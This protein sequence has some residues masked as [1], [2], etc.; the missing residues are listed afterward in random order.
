MSS[1]KKKILLIG[2]PLSDNGKKVLANILRDAKIPLSDVAFMDLR[3]K[4]AMDK[5]ESMDPK[6]I[7]PMGAPALEQTLG[8]EKITKWRGSI[9]DY[10]GYKAIPTFDPKSIMTNWSWRPICLM[11]FLRIARHANED[12]KPME[13]TLISTPDFDTIIKELDRLTQGDELV[14]F[15]IENPDGYI[16]CIS[17]SDRPDW[18]MCVPFDRFSSVEQEVIWDKVKELCLST[19]PMVAH[20]AQYDMFYLWNDKG[21][22]VKNLYMDTMIAGNLLYAEFPKGLDFMVSIFTEEPY[23]KYMRKTK[24]NEVLY[25]Y[26]CLDAATTIEIAYKIK[27]K[28]EKANMWMFYHSYLNRLIKPI[29]RMTIRG[30]RIDTKTRDEAIKQYAEEI[31]KLQKEINEL[32]GHD[33]NV[34]S[35]KQMKDYLYTELGLPKQYRRRKNKNGYQ[36]SLSADEEAIEKLATDHP[37]PLFHRILKLRGLKKIKGTYLEAKVD[38]DGRMRASYIIG[39]TETGR[40]ASRKSPRGTGT[41]LQNVPKGIA[42]RIFTPD[43]EKVFVSAD[44]SQAEAYIVAYLAGEEALIRLFETGAK[45]HNQVASNVFG[46]PE[47][48]ITDKQY[49]LAKR[50]VHASNYGMGYNSFAKDTGVTTS[51]AKE[52]LKAYF[53]AYPRVK[54]WHK[55]V[56]E[57]VTSTR[58]LV[59]PLGRKR[60]FMAEDDFRLRREAYAYIPQST[61][62]DILNMGL[63]QLDTALP[64]GAELM[65]QVHDSVVV[66]CDPTQLQLVIET[67]KKCLTRPI[68]IT[69]ISGKVRTCEIPVEFEVGD[70]WDDLKK[71]T[72]GGSRK[73]VDDGH[74]R[75]IR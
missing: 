7:V 43:G 28:L 50:I 20:N 21:I 29:L 63:I 71:Y 16:T 36:E 4:D 15:D 57:K 33:L 65:L 62:A 6:V 1:T 11:D 64:E 70:T 58:V 38:T 8:K 3:D 22:W 61:V 31:D 68:Q 56:E 59:T 69:D 41:N 66:Q 53:V 39:G 27:E 42:R 34:S 46:V 35:P 23:F 48:N 72:P 14:S 45:I 60:W 9:L 30:L 54:R 25:H 37:S 51:E 73:W 2:L 10:N 75:G 26:N 74:L 55:K 12:I 49:K 44:L 32:V 52:Y 24:D 40:L 67:L 19:T 5:I 18:A 13:R 17:F 47:S